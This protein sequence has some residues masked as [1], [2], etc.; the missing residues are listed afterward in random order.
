MTEMRCPWCKRKVSITYN[1]G[2]KAFAVWHSGEPCKLVEP[3]WID[4]EYAKSLN[5]A[6][7]VWNSWESEVK[8]NE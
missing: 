2:E 4:G 6:Y 1:S 8:P 3:I 7:E 5:E